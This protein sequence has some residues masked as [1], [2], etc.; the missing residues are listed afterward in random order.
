MPRISESECVQVEEESEV[1]SLSSL[2]RNGRGSARALADEAPVNHDARTH[3]ITR[4]ALPALTIHLF[5]VNMQ[6][7]VSEYLS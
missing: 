2:I 7:K 3:K 1:N 6:I 5:G 4:R